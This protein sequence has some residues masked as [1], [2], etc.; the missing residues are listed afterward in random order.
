VALLRRAQFP[1]DAG[2]LAHPVRPA[3][4]SEINN[5][6][7]ATVY[8]RVRNW[9]ACWPAGWATRAFVAAWTATSRAT[10]AALPPSRISSPRWAMPM[11][12][13]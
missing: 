1:E 13:I 8:G 7:T 6:Y 3:Q 2:P 5:F 12:S 11:A 9:C 4:Y 10:T